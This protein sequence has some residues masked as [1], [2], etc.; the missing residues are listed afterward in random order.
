MTGLEALLPEHFARYPAMQPQD[1]V[2][3]LYQAA[4]GGGHLVSDPAGSLAR[5]RQE[6]DAVPPEPD[7]PA[8]EH[9]GGGSARMNLASPA[10]RALPPELLNRMFV[11]S[12][13][14]GDSGVD[15][16]AALELLQRLTREGRAPFSPEALEPYLAGYTAAGCPAVRH[17]EAY[18]AAYRPAYR[19][20]DARYAR[21]LLLLRCTLPLLQPGRTA[22]IAIDGRAASGKTTAA[23]LLAELLDASVVHMDDFFLPLT[24]RTPERLA[25][26]GGNVDYERFAEEVL[27]RLRAPGAFSYARFDC[28]VMA[29]RGTRA[30]PAAPLRIVEG[31]YS[32]HPYFGAYADLSVYSDIQP[33]KQLARIA[34]RNGAEKLAA[35]RERW[36]P[37]EERYFD[38]FRIR[39]RAGLVLED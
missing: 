15:F 30:V 33:E 36:I 35:F 7:A 31:S 18:R 28:E 24:K 8:F 14:R 12:A 26:P 23:A 1:A 13:A 29:L 21:I 20:V 6:L 34:V 27:P 9:V 37:M 22:V 32:C 16:P 3:L 39:S 10:V 2:K 5:L 38:A 25:E 17:S 4:F 19:V 11:L